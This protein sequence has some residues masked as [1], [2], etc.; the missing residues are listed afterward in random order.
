MVCPNGKKHFES[1]AH[2][3]T[4]MTAVKTREK[5]FEI[6]EKWLDENLGDESLSPVAFIQQISDRCAC[7]ETSGYI[8]FFE[9]GETRAKIKV[10][11]G[12]GDDDACEDDVIQII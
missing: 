9:G 4:P 11:N 3:L 5:A 2:K 1:Q 10:C 7:G 8:A 12:C 6:L